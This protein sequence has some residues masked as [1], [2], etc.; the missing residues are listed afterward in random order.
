MPLANGQATPVLQHRPYREDRLVVVVPEQHALA[1]SDSVAF[2]DV[3]EWDIVSLQAGSSISL[4]MRAAAAQAG[5][6][7]HPRHPVPQPECTVRIIHHRPCAWT[8]PR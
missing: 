3:L 5:P 7:P 8:V 4:A 1:H 6:A 2:A